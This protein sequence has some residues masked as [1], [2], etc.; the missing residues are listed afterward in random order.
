MERRQ[1][2]GTSLVPD[3]APEKR[4]CRRS[5]PATGYFFFFFF[6]GAALSVTVTVLLFGWPPAG[7]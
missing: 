1:A 6:A 2:P 5:P 4:W 7:V 3:A